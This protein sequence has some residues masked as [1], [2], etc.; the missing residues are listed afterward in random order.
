[1]PSS[2]SSTPK[3]RNSTRRLPLLPEKVASSRKISRLESV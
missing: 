3:F 2:T 1:V